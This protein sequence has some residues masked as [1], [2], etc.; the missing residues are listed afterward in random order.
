MSISMTI[1]KSKIYE[2]CFSHVQI[3]KS[4]QTVNV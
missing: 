1:E 3:E 4:V 2:G